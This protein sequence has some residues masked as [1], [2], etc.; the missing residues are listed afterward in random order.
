MYCHIIPGNVTYAAALI[1]GVPVQYA[2]S[3]AWFAGMCLH[4]N[5]HTL[6]PRPETE[7]LVNW[8]AN[9]AASHL[10]T[11][12]PLK[13]LEVGTGSGCIAI[14]LQKK[15]PNAQITA[16]DISSEAIKVAHANALANNAAITFIT[17][18]FLN[19]LGWKNLGNYDIIISNPPY[20]LEAEKKT[21]SLHVVDHEPHAALFVPDHDALVFY[22]A[23]ANFSTTHLNNGGA[24]FVEINQSLGT[25]TKNIL[26][27]KNY[28]TN[29]RKDLFENDRMILATKN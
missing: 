19:E 8:C 20:I 11:T 6:I 7:E 1:K 26:Q 9:W 12:S 27:E 3:Q 13:I 24:I 10:K 15:L 16:L 5:K 25:A 23:I 4:V 21:M 14:A 29:L 17:L 2:L 28:N 18:D 22:L